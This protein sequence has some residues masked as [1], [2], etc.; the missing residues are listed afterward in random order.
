[1]DR[2]RYDIG[3]VDHGKKT[4]F[5]R[6]LL[7]FDFDG[8]YIVYSPRPLSRKGGDDEEGIMKRMRIRKERG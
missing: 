1:M 6:D 5:V 8:I 7:Q 3:A 2:C 4:N